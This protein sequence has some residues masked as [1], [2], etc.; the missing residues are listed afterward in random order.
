MTTLSEVKA[1]QP[2]WFSRKNKKFFGDV[3]YRILHG[4]VSKKPFLVR[5]TYAWSDMFGRPKT[6]HWKI[7]RL[8]DDLEIGE[9]LNQ[10]FMGLEL[11]KYFLRGE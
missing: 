8:K 5:S 11:V 9:L 2:E 3:S 4:G 7:N 1:R 6:L 10:D